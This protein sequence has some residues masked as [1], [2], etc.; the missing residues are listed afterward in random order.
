MN[1]IYDAR[2]I[3]VPTCL[4]RS[5]ASIC[6]PVFQ[7]FGF[8]SGEW[9]VFRRNFVYDLWSSLLSNLKFIEVGQTLVLG[10]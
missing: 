6:G 7:I 4:N 9:C 5:K 1:G 8:L 2:I 3:K 10:L